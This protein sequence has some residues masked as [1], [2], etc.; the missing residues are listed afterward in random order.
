ML[1]ASIFIPNFSLQALFAKRRELQTKAI[2]LIDGTPPL[3]RVVAANDKAIKAG[4]EIGLLKAQ[5]EA[6]GAEPI[7]SSTDLEK[8]VHATALTCV[9]QF[10][11]TNEKATIFAVF[12]FLLRPSPNRGARRHSTLSQPFVVAGIKTLEVGDSW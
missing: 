10:S 7:S 8:S 5:A 6:V 3:L 1:F 2:A 9:R 11:P 12:Y 4:V